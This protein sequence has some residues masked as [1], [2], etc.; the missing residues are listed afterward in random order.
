MEL[1]MF[2]IADE[3][4]TSKLRPNAAW[5]TRPDRSCRIDPC[6]W[7]SCCRKAEEAAQ[8]NFRIG[9]KAVIQT[10]SGN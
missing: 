10:S 7:P 2:V 1:N 3:R 9:P 4:H 8:L 6:D 5:V